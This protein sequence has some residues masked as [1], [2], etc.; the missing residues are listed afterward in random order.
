MRL[1]HSVRV[2]NQV[3]DNITKIFYFY[4]I[5]LNNKNLKQRFFE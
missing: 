1:S 5:D 3:I 4:H 2:I